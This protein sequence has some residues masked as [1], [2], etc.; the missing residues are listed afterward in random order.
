MCN[1]AQNILSERVISKLVQQLHQS[2]YCMT[3]GTYQEPGSDKPNTG[4]TIFG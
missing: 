2:V 4:C 3:I 1:S